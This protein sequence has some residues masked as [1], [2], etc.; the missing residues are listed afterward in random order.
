MSIRTSFKD[1]SEGHQLKDYISTLEKIRVA[2]GK[3]II[4]E[5]QAIKYCSTHL[6]IWT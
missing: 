1:N 6:G 2:Q 3:G 4:T 5:M